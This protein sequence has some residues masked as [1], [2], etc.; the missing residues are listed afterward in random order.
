[1]LSSR[2]IYAFGLLLHSP[3]LATAAIMPSEASLASTDSLHVFQ[4][5]DGI[6]FT[7]IRH[8]YSTLKEEQQKNLRF[9]LSIP[10]GRDDDLVTRDI[11]KMLLTTTFKDC[12]PIEGQGDPYHP[13]PKILEF[14]AS[15]QHNGI[16]PLTRVIQLLANP[17]GKPGA[18][19]Q[20][21]ETYDAWLRGWLETP[22]MVIDQR[23]VHLDCQS[24]E[25]MESCKAMI[26]R[27]GPQITNDDSDDAA[28]AAVE[29]HA[30]RAHVLSQNAEN[31]PASYTE[32]A[33]SSAAELE[34]SP[35]YRYAIDGLKT[36]VAI[37]G[38]SAS[39][40]HFLSHVSRRAAETAAFLKVTEQYRGRLT[41]ALSEFDYSQQK[42]TIKDLQRIA[43]QKLEASQQLFIT[44]CTGYDAMIQRILKN[45]LP[46]SHDLACKLMGASFTR[47]LAL[48]ERAQ[49]KTISDIT[50]K[51]IQDIFSETRDI[52]RQ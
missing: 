11:I 38:E 39:F 34:A 52:L 42:R 47:L 21:F 22:A 30:S 7:T 37:L 50:L 44:A 19:N 25:W 16:T 31:I 26:A 43:E 27:F 12:Y 45:S 1:M 51:E 9:W 4:K 20:S 14:Y 29:R 33:V 10:E 35:E 23:Y 40:H 18:R 32:K 5:N 13:T 48:S 3:S 28:G 36:H 15:Y 46:E 17:I 8:S 41:I 49:E 6:V 2:L 24:A